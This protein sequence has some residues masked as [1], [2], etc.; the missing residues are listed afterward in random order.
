MGEASTS[1]PVPAASSLRRV[2]AD[3]LLGELIP[4]YTRRW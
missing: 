3:T 1:A 2:V 4:R